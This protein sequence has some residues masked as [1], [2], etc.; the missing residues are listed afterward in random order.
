MPV[1]MNIKACITEQ[2]L[3]PAFLIDNIISDM[4]TSATKATMPK[5]NIHRQVT[6]NNA[7]ETMRKMSG[8][9]RT[10]PWMRKTRMPPCTHSI[11][12]RRKSWLKLNKVSAAIMAMDIVSATQR[13]TLERR[14]EAKVVRPSNRMST[15]RMAAPAYI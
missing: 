4:V 8:R 9:L 7:M 5:L 3:L 6:P 13:L 11:D 1:T 2:H 12:E 10:I 15:A 14:R